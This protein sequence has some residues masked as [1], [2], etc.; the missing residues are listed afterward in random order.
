MTNIRILNKECL[1][2]IN[3]NYDNLYCIENKKLRILS[4]NKSCDHPTTL[5]GYLLNNGRNPCRSY[6][7][8]KII[9]KEYK[10]TKF[11]IISKEIEKFLKDD[12]LSIDLI[13]ARGQEFIIEE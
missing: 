8:D 11:Y 12:Q 2:K 1:F 13:E 9:K 3:M 7:I 10:N 6:W 5:D 4:I